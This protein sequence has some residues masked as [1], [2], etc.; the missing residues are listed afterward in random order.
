[1]AYFCVAYS[2]CSGQPSFLL[3]VSSVLIACLMTNPSTTLSSG[4]I[5]SVVGQAVD[6]GLDDVGF[7]VSPTGQFEFNWLI[8]DGSVVEA[9]LRGN[10]YMYM[11]L[12]PDSLIWFV[13][14]NMKVFEARYQHIFSCANWGRTCIS[15]GGAVCV[16]KWQLV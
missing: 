3:Q 1:M 5:L 11:Y 6:A 10:F 16:G 2:D 13:P 15:T 14:E 8:Y 7:G 4:G 9:G 12:S